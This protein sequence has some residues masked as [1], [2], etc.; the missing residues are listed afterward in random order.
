MTREQIETIAQ[1]VAQALGATIAVIEGLSSSDP[2][3]TGYRVTF[4]H[5]GQGYAYSLRQSFIHSAEDARV[6]LTNSLQS[7]IHKASQPQMKPPEHKDQ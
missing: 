2:N 5:N 1:D 3:D 7:S 6:Y 4:N